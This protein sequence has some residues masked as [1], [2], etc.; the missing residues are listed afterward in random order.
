MIYTHSGIVF[1]LLNPAPEMVSIVDIATSLARQARFNGHTMSFYSVASHSLFVSSRLPPRLQLAGLLHDAAEAYTGDI[2]TPVKRLL[3][4]Y[5]ELED[6]I[7]S[8]VQVRFSVDNLVPLHDKIRE[9]DKVALATEALAFMRPNKLWNPG[10]GTGM[11]LEPDVSHEHATAA[12][13]KRLRELAN[14]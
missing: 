11:I 5:E 8:A 7:L 3:K 12:F 13:T 10:M 6:R 4:G 14:E 1:D 2:A 9:Q